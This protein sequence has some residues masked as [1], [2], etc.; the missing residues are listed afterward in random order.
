VQMDML[1]LY[2]HLCKV[3][4]FL[5]KRCP[6]NFRSAVKRV[7]LK[8]YHSVDDLIK[9]LTVCVRFPV[10]TTGAIQRKSVMALTL[11]WRN[12]SIALYGA[13]KFTLSDE[14]NSSKINKSVASSSSTFCELP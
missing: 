4:Y 14:G 6:V 12:P 2:P 8:F 5:D 1:V 7:T 13:L 9:W 11:L 10:G 3:V